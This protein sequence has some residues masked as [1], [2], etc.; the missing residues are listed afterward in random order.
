M[1]L[2]IFDMGGVLAR[3]FDVMPEAARRLGME[4]PD[5]LRHALVDIDALLTGAITEAEYWLRFEAASGVRAAENWWDTLFA[6]SVDADVEAIVRSV[7]AKGRV[8]C[9]T[10]VIASHYDWLVAKGRYE[11]F[12]AVYAS[13][14]M[15][16]RKPDPRFWLRILE[17]EGT[18]PDEAFFIDDMAENVEAARGLGIASHLFSGAAGLRRAIAGL[19]TEGGILE[20]R[21][22]A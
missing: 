1:M 9:G 14:L 4:W 10:N 3:D 21:L 13:H 19:A 16:L 12:D 5:F 15:G 20:S 6:P 7:Q 2:Y 17:A 8:V 22:E 11:S 18:K